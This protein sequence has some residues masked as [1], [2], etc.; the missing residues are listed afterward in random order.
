M[1]NKS[2]LIKSIIV[3][4]ILNIYLAWV[5]T[6]VKSID[7]LVTFN[8]LAFCFLTAVIS[9][10]QYQ[11]K[12]IPVSKYSLKAKNTTECCET[13]LSTYKL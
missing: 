8:F 1:K 10:K 12:L 11:K 6:E 5:A 3:I 4:G 2:F 9:E 7:Q 13:L